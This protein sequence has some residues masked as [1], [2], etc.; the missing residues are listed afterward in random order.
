MYMFPRRARAR[1]ILKILPLLISF[2]L[3]P[4]PCRT[5]AQIDRFISVC[6]L[7]FVPLLIPFLL[8]FSTRSSNPKNTGVCD[9]T[10]LLCEPRP[11]NP[12]ETALQ[13]LIWCSGNIISQGYSSPEECFF[14]D[15]GETSAVIFADSSSPQISAI[16]AGHFTEGNGSLLKSLRNLRRLPQESTFCKGGCSGNRV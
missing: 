5:V 4:F 10:F 14:T 11:C 15:T 12:P 8:P 1:P 7:L 13:P 9:K 3:L 2:T 16:L 6:C